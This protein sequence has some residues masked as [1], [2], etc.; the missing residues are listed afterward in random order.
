MQGPAQGLFFGVSSAHALALVVPV[1]MPLAIWVLASVAQLAGRRGFAPARQLI[2]GYN[3]SATL[4]R[5]VAF[6]LALAGG[7]HVALAAGQVRTDVGIVVLFFLNG[8]AFFALSLSVFAWGS[9]RPAAIVLLGYDIAGILCLHC[10]GDRTPG[11]GRRV[12]VCTG[13]DYT[14]PR[15]DTVVSEASA[16]LGD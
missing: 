14:G 2:E 7:I 6:L 13:T 10:P 11:P 15:L 8:A 9:W 5:V 12:C 3:S 16:T 4:D 1:V